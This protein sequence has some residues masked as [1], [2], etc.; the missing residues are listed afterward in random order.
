LIIFCTFYLISNEVE[1]W[2]EN[3]SFVFIIIDEFE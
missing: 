2:G 1:L 3:V